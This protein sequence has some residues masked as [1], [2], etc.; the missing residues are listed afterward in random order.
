[1]AAMTRRE[2]TRGDILPMEDYSAQRKDWRAKLAEVKR[3]RRVAVGPVAT[4]HFET[5]L[6][7]WYQIHEML[8][9]E[10]GGEEQISD[11]LAA[12]NPL[13]PKGDELVATVMFEIDDPERRERF[14]AGLGR[15]EKTAFLNSSVWAGMPQPARRF[16]AG[17]MTTIN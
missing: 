14:L 10:K 13:V 3:D 9:I 7:M 11:E 8:F 16:I 2:V 5:Y 12:Y 17:G 4:F 6:T 1:M 15:V